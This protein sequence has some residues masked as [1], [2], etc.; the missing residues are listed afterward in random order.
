MSMRNPI[1]KRSLMAIT[2]AAGITIFAMTGAPALAATAPHGKPALP[3]SAASTAPARTVHNAPVPAPRKPAS[4]I[5]ADTSCANEFEILSGFTT[6]ATTV[7]VGTSVTLTATMTCDIGPT[8]YYVQIFDATTGALVATCGAGT[9]CGAT[10]S[11]G[12]ASTHDYIAYLDSY[13]T[14]FPPASVSETSLNRYVTWEALSGNF[15]VSLFG[16]AN[17]A[18]F[19]GP[20]TYTAYVNQNVGPTPYWI[21]IFDET[22]GTLLAVCGTGTSCTA[23]F[24][25][26]YTGD[27]LV[28][29]VSGYSTTLPPAATQASSGILTTVRLQNIQ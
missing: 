26:S 19:A 20:G 16:P 15:Y 2:A 13:S 12:V 6:S 7:P 9:S 3:A 5:H 21:E 22:T 29:F 28:A 10:V 24:T 4:R 14:T 8:P 18:Y 25:P 1:G 17:V 27:N 23:S 11:Q